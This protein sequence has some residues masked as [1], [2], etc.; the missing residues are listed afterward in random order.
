M[1]GGHGPFSNKF[2]MGCDN[3]LEFEVVTPSG[4]I[5]I[6]N[7]DSYPDLFWALRGGGGSTFG[8]VTKTTMK[9][10]PKPTM[11]GINLDI[12]AG[13]TRGQLLD[14]MAYFWAMT[15][16]MTDFG[17]VGYPTIR[18]ASPYPG[19]LWA[20]GK[21]RR[22]I[23]AFWAPIAAKMTQLGA[24]V[25]T[26][27]TE[28]EL[29]QWLTTIVNI[30]LPLP[31]G[32]FMAS[33]LISRSALNEKNTPAIRTMLD[34]VLAYTSMILPYPVAGGQVTTNRN[35][36]IGLNPAW[37]DAVMHMVVIGFDTKGAIAAMDPLSVDHGAYI[38]EGYPTEADWKTT[39]FGPRAHYA[40]LL[41][42]KKKYD[43]RNTLWCTPCVGS[44]LLAEHADG[45]L[46]NV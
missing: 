2:G 38:G 40:K 15:P 42:I 39:F 27:A 26:K 28:K 3:V 44:D 13:G 35:L 21:S 24:K 16:N 19:T 22:D 36:D 32:R 12:S 11:Y 17:L 41:A 20:P 43:P 6:V 9:T 31:I 8:V 18:H 1:G 14:A 34:K 29:N 5:L 30:N 7:D 10:Y 33:R 23:E 46:Y 25:T 45:K 4:E 37:R